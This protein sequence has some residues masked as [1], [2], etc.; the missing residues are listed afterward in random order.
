MTYAIATYDWQNV[1]DA[2]DGH[3]PG[4]I[5]RLSKRS[6]PH[7]LDQGARESVGLPQGQSADYRWELESGE[8]LHVRDFGTHYE[9]HIDLVDPAVDLLAHLANDAPGTMITGS[10]AGGALIGTAVARTAAGALV[11]GLVGGLVGALGVALLTQD[12]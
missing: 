4:S 11:G 10:A 12:D 3:E 6:V 5:L 7:P 2:L 8:S 1:L 9:A